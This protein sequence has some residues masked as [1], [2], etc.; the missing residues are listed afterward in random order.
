MASE[1]LLVMSRI[2]WEP[3]SDAETELEG[4]SEDEGSGVGV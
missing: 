4:F 1:P 3:R 2:R